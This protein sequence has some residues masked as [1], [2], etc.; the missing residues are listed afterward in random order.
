MAKRTR[1]SSVSSRRS[2]AKRTRY[3]GV[4]RRVGTARVLSA[5]VRRANAGVQ[6]LTRMIETKENVWKSGANVALDHNQL[7]S[8]LAPGS[9][10]RLN[11][12]QIGQGVG[13]GM[14]NGGGARI[15]DEIYCKKI[16]IRGMIENALARSKVHYRIM[17][18]R[19][20]KGDTPTRDTL[21]RGN[22]GNKLI[23]LINTERYTIV[24]QRIF[25]ISGTGA[26]SANSVSATGIPLEAPTIGGD[27]VGGIGSKVFTMVIP[28]SKFGKGGRVQYE[29]NS[30][31]Q[32]KFY[33]YHLMI[34]T[35]DWY[36]TP[37]S[38]LG[39]FNTVGRINE[40]YAQ[41]YFKDA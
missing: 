15:G 38:L 40:L 29:N 5:S 11:V 36:G 24:K 31:S 18:I 28:G 3:V 35:Y 13:D 19:A 22:V 17:L 30:G 41:M 2:G 7:H 39:V 21:F 16:V 12:L 27:F 23:D 26:S 4:R 10:G 32:V 34:M 9:G 6:R 1:S 20:A 8:V 25:T 33:D 37:D 14:S